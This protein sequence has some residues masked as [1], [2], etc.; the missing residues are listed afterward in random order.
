MYNSITVMGRIVNDPILNVTPNGINYCSFRIAADRRF[1][2]KGEERR[3]DFFNVTGWRNTAE[4]ISKY[5]AK[6]SM[7]LIVGEMQVNQFTDKNGNTRDWYEIVVDRACFTGE[8]KR[9]ASPQQPQV[10]SYSPSAAQTQPS[11]NNN[12]NTSAPPPPAPP[13]NDD[14]PF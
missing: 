8:K 2:T 6:G 4:F 9:D 3:T 5:F 1:Q 7:I 12:N 14:Y 10:Q 13:Q 11:Y